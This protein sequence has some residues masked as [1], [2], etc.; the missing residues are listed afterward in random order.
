RL[1][2][3]V[4]CGTHGGAGAVPVLAA[5]HRGPFGH[6]I[7]DGALYNLIMKYYLIDKIF[8]GRYDGVNADVAV[9]LANMALISVGASQP[10]CQRTQLRR[11]AGWVIRSFHHDGD[12]FP[13]RISSEPHRICISSDSKQQHNVGNAFFFGDGSG[14]SSGS[15]YNI[16]ISG[17]DNV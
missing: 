17:S 2:P 8:P 3:P 4:G 13:I 6:C 5:R 11:A 10:N 12:D 16:V 1:G 14:F 15:R 7:D 9:R